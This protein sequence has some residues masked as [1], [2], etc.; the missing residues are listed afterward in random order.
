MEIE[1]WFEC[2]YNFYV[3]LN[4]KGGDVRK[5]S[6]WNEFRNKFE[7]KNLGKVYPP[8]VRWVSSGFSNWS[9]LETPRGIVPLFPVSPADGNEGVKNIYREPM[10]NS[11]PTERDS[12]SWYYILPFVSCS[13]PLLI[14]RSKRDCFYL[15][16]YSEP[17][18]STFNYSYLWPWDISSLRRW[19][20]STKRW[21]RSS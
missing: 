17:T 10:R 12:D 19:M 3:N 6:M 14:P 2:F 8:P 13:V 20:E 9:I 15:W 4:L 11:I 16:E 21:Y 18:R 1:L 5:S 7:A